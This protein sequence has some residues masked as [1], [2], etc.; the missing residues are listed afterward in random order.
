MLENAGVEALH[1]DAGCYDNWYWPHPPI[2]QS[3]GCMVDMAAKIKPHVRVPVITEGRKDYGGQKA[4]VI[5]GGSVGCET[6]L[7]LAQKGWSVVVA[8][9]LSSAASDLFEANRTMLL[10]LL[11]EDGVEV[12]TETKVTRGHLCKVYVEAHEGQREFQ[13]DVIILATGRKAVTDLTE[14][15]KD[16]VDE[17]VTIGDC[18]SPRRIKNAI[19]EAYKIGIII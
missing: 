2:Y 11:K 17:A 4:F 5:G 13:T 16:L 1:V 6:A 7:Y 10:A 3:P 18:N 12:W 9:M 15:S 14:L 19:W 8:E